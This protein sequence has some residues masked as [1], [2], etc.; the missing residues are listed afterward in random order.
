MLIDRKT[1]DLRR[2]PEL[3]KARNWWLGFCRIHGRHP[4]DRNRA[5]NPGKCLAS[6]S[7][8][9]LG[10]GASFVLHGTLNREL[11]LEPSFSGECLSFRKVSPSEGTARK[12]AESNNLCQRG[13]VILTSREDRAFEAD[14]GTSGDDAQS[15]ASSQGG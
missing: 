1:L 5:G 2:E 3:R 8:R 13:K 6:P 14:T 4:E 15:V 10:N 12:D 11:F 7:R 9:I